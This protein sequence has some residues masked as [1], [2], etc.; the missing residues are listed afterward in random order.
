MMGQKQIIWPALPALILMSLLLDCG[1]P[2][3]SEDRFSDI[4]RKILDFMED[5]GVP[6]VS[7]AVAKNGKIIWEESFGW[8]NR[9]KQI[10]ATPN[11]M[12]ELASIAKVFTTTGLMV[13][14]E[15]GLIDLDAPVATYLGDVKIKAFDVDPSGVTLRRIVQHTSGLPMYWGAPS[16]ADSSHPITQKEILDR[17]AILAFKPGEQELYSNIGIAMLTYVIEK[18]SR[19]PYAEFLRQHVFLPLGMTRTE[20]IS[21]P[22]TADDF[23]QEYMPN[24]EPWI[25]PEGTYGSAHDLLRFGMFH[26]KDHLP[27][28]KPIL[29]DSTIDLMQSAVDPHSDF[30]LPWWVWEYEGSPALV[31]TGA[32]GAIIALLPEANLAVVVL[33]NRLQADTPRICE[34][35]CQEML[36]DFDKKE[37][38]PAVARTHRKIRP[39]PLSRD[40]LTGLWEGAILTHE[41]SLAVQ[42]SFIR[43]SSPRM[44]CFDTGGSWGPWVETMASLK[45]DYSQGVFSAYFPIRIPISDTRSHDHWTWIYVGMNGDTLRGYAVAHA[46]GGPHFGLPYFVKLYRANPPTD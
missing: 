46:A 2:Q 5:D 10:R 9:E 28:Q 18:V 20:R 12:Y 1:S 45:G 19:Q 30:R 24:G 42:L 6:S 37:K 22:G 41:C 36:A 38:I 3:G 16:P 11:T 34:W 17:Y 44:R 29:S 27:D 13:L 7:V 33:S 43:D 39:Q 25:Y 15:R 32:S 35:I 40:A 21:A 8:A 4:R 23:A 14:R 26:L 31:F